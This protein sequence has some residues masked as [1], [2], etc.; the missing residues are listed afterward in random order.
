MDRSGLGTKR[1]R[2]RIAVA[3]FVALVAIALGWPWFSNFEAHRAGYISAV[4]SWGKG[5]GA[6]I[7]P[8]AQERLKHYQQQGDAASFKVGFALGRK[9]LLEQMRDAAGYADTCLLYVDHYARASETALLI[10]FPSKLSEVE[11][12]FWLLVLLTA[13]LFLRSLVSTFR[14]PG[15]LPSLSTMKNWRR[16]LSL[17]CLAVSVACVAAIALQVPLDG[18]NWEYYATD[19][20]RETLLATA[21]FGLGPLATCFAL[22]GVS[23]WVIGHKARRKREPDR[24]EPLLGKVT[25]QA[26]RYDAMEAVPA[27]HRLRDVAANFDAMNQRLPAE[28]ANRTGKIERASP[29]AAKR[30]KKPAPWSQVLRMLDQRERQERAKQPRAA[31]HSEPDSVR[32]AELNRFAPI[33]ESS[34]SGARRPRT[35]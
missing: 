27:A 35:R 11:W 16:V 21:L 3:S 14:Q 31:A 23:R 15:I 32:Q 7:S 9:Q 26:P 1:Y 6:K 8:S 18:L 34:P 29:R 24:I 17:L 33:N 5:C 28:T 19:P 25:A 12:P 20:Q 30:G 2:N 10:A 22:F 4:L 13:W